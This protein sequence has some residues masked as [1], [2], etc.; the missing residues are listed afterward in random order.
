MPTAA[1]RPSSHTALVTGASSGLGAAFAEELDAGRTLLVP[2]WR[3]R[4]TAR[5]AGLLPRRVV[6]AA[7]ERTTRRVIAT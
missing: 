5:V 4:L 6:L 2:G 1:L 7:A 3:N